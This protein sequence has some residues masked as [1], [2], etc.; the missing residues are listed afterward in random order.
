M[1]KNTRSSKKKEEKSRVGS[2]K[3]QKKASKTQ[4]SIKKTKKKSSAANNTK[5]QMS[6]KTSNTSIEHTK[7]ETSVMNNNTVGSNKGKGSK[8]GK[9]A[10]EEAAKIWTRG[11]ETANLTA[12][13]E[14][15]RKIVTPFDQSKIWQANATRNRPYPDYRCLDGNRIVVHLGKSDY[16]NASRVTVPN[17][18]RTALLVQMPLVDQIDCVENFWRMVFNEQ[19]SQ[20]HLIAQPKEIE[21]GGFTKL[22]SQEANGYFY[23]NDFF[24]NTRKADKNG[25]EKMDTYVIELLPQG[26]SNSVICTVYVHAYWKAQGGPE[27]FYAPIKAATAMAKTDVDKSAIAIVSFRGSGRNSSLLTTAVVVSQFLKGITPN[28]KDIVRT[29]REQRPMAVDSRTQY[30]SIYLAS[31]WLVKAKSS[32]QNEEMKNGLKKFRE[33]FEGASQMSQ[34]TK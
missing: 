33:K 29:I 14:E 13:Y 24:V 30:N 11:L 18:D 27:K 26:C 32:G 28:I 15:I 6:N 3:V 22:F 5:S 34:I 4:G 16:I 8:K 1:K 19:C 23:A 20:V 21:G 17:F 2:K 9:W 31:C 7:Q 10:G 12:E 25:E